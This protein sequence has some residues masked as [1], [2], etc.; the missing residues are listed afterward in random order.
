MAVAMRITNHYST[1]HAVASFATAREQMDAALGRVTSGH[2]FEQASEDPT[3]ALA[4]MQNDAQARAI[5]QYRRNIGTANARVS[6]EDGVL[7]S[8][9]SLLVRAKELAVAQASDTSTI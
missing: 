8:L 5:S 7:D 4:V 6:L 9:S 3:G 2:R 1:Q